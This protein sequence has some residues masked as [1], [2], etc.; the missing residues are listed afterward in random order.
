[1]PHL[2]RKSKQ[3]LF[4]QLME[5][6]IQQIESG[7]LAPGDRLLPER[8]MAAAYGINRST[9]NHALEELT[10]L[11]WLT[12]RQGSGTEVAKG[13]W[14][15]RQAPQHQ[16]QHLLA[17][18]TIRQ[19]P[20]LTEKNR[21]SKD[22]QS[23]D[24]SGGEL[25][26]DLVPDFEFPALSWDTLIKEE[27]RLSDLG[28]APLQR[29]I[30]EKLARNFSLPLAEQQLLITSGSTQGISLILQTLLQPGDV[31]ATEDP[32]FL[33][34][35]PLVQ[36]LGIR[37]EGIPMD[38]EGIMPSELE[39]QLLT[40]KIKLL[41]LNPTFQNPTGRCL[42]YERRQRVVEICRKYY[43]P[44]IED[45]VFGELDFGVA[46]PRLKQLAPEQVLY[47]GSLSKIFGSAIKIG[48]LLAPKNLILSLA[49]TR[50]QLD[51]DS[52]LFAQLLANAALRD[53]HYQQQHDQLVT[54]LSLR[55]DHF[56][57]SLRPLQQDWAFQ[58]ISGGLYYW[59]TW[60]HQPLTRQEWH[61]FLQEKLLVAPSF[62]FSNDTMAMR[63]NYTSLTNETSLSF[64]QRLT[65]VTNLLKE[66]GQKQ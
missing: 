59:L 62:L 32:S 1:M 31:I 19:D 29:I 6:I 27:Q 37:I 22:P 45:D 42:S 33:F 24:V 47:L 61:Y 12:R 35:L 48:W 65:K 5:L 51:S 11:G 10:S 4:Q 20:Y 44:I 52:N 55:S 66:K 13:R 2:D 41:Y 25:P 58:P 14:G 63:I 30:K 3:P 57:E 64:I 17:Q 15:S 43:V 28:Y 7:E 54:E 21:L 36:S 26:A 16:W 8:K 56:C 39:K 40:K 9:V 18:R 50:Q 60:R 23:I 46:L 53:S 49:N 34:A 38:N